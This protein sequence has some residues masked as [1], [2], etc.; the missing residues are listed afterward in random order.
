M[1]GIFLYLSWKLCST[2][3]ISS[4]GFK[5][6]CLIQQQFIFDQQLWF[7]A[8]QPV[9]FA[10]LNSKLFSLGEYMLSPVQSAIET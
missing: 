7:V 9:H 4:D 1:F 8:E 5:K 6:D 10:Q 3:A 2:D